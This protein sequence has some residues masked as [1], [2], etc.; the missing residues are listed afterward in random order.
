M[1][2]VQW[3]TR[4][5]RSRRGSDDSNSMFKLALIVLIGF[6]GWVFGPAYFARFRMNAIADQTLTM[7]RANDITVGSNFLKSEIEDKGL[8]KYLSRDDCTLTESAGEKHLRCTW[9]TDVNYYVGTKT[10]NFSVHKYVDKFS[11]VQDG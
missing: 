3:H 1:S 8:G 4:A 2:A 6:G 5:M 7:W 11:F 10:L 9:S